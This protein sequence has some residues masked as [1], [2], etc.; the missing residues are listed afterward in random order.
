[1]KKGI[2]SNLHGRT[3]GYITNCCETLFFKEYCS[4]G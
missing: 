1:M 2:S 3:K 4:K